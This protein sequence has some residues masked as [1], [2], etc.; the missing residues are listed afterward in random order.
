MNTVRFILLLSLLTGLLLAIGYLT[1]RGK[2]VLIALIISALMNMGS[3]WYADKI[4]LSMYQAK[5]VTQDQA[6]ELYQLVENLAK[7]AHLPTPR[8]YI[9]PSK[10]PNAFATGRDENHAAVAVTEGILKLVDREEL[11]GVLAHELSH[12]KNRDVLIS[13]MTATLAGAVVMLARFAVFFGSDDRGLIPTIAMAIVAPVAATAIQMA[14]S[15][16]REYEADASAARLTG[17]PEA[18]ASALLKLAHLSEV[19][20]MNANPA[21]AHMFIVNPLSGGAIMH[22]FSTHPPIE[23]RV[24]KLLS[25]KRK[26]NF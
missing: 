10:T 15:R 3:Y 22:L 17:K 11:E 21:T 5:P 16:T 14:I 24:K 18:L 7:K 13:T 6:P 2:G 25:M 20:P 19:K 8:I 23:K 9:V 26:S 12:I 4:V 1:A